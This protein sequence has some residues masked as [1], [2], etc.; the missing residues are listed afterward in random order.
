MTVWLSRLTL[1][2]LSRTVRGDLGDSA[3]GIHL[4]RRVMSLFP[5]IEA[6]D[7]RAKLGVLFRAE[8]TPQGYALLVQSTHEPDVARLPEDYGA[9]R[10]RP[11]DPLLEALKPGRRI[12]YRCVANAVRRPGATT[13][14]L[15]KLKAMVPLS[16]RAADEW[17]Q[18]QAAAAGLDMHTVL[19]RPV[20]AVRGPRGTSGEA[21]KQRMHHARTQFDGLAVINDADAL[22]E[23]IISGIG[24]AKSYGC[25]LLTVAPA[26][27]D[28]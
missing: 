4:H 6:E 22:R 5:D 25:G 2:P 26:G 19:S 11:L 24:R 9:L 7:A 3:S 23:R 21:A 15:Y 28:A 16:G 18:R 17:W 20:D 10:S 8:D 14:E 12:R 13:R 1:N 27:G